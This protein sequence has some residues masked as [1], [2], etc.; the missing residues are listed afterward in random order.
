ML[1][2]PPFWNSFGAMS[3]AIPFRSRAMRIAAED[4]SF[5]FVFT[6]SFITAVP[7][8]PTRKPPR[9]GRKPSRM[10]SAAA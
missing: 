5:R 2:K 6:P 3:R 8:S 7:H 4:R 9:T 1:T 10:V